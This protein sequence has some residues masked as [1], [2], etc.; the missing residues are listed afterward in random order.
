[1]L[2]TDSEDEADTNLRMLRLE[3]KRPMDRIDRLEP[4]LA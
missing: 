3:P 4:K 2:R 1:M